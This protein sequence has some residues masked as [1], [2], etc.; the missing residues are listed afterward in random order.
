MQKLK[1]MI[2]DDS[3]LMRRK[4]S[5]SYDASHYDLVAIASNGHE[6][7]NSFSTHKPHIVTMDLTMPEL[8]GID[9][10]KQLMNIDPQVKILVVSAI[11]D[12]ATGIKALEQGASGF[13]IKP[14]SETQLSEALNIICEDIHDD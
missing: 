5:R 13:I 11:S 12:E 2:V 3:M 10:I 4:I 8:D 6:A 9:C 7:I 1:L 14:F